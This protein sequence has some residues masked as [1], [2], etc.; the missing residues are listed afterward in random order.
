MSNCWFVRH[1]GHGVL[2][3]Q[4]GREMISSPF[5]SELSI[6]AS[7]LP[8]SSCSWRGPAWSPEE[9]QRAVRGSV[10]PP[11]S[12]PGWC[13]VVWLPCFLSPSLPPR[14]CPLLL[15]HP[16]GQRE[17]SRRAP[18]A[19]RGVPHGTG[20]GA[21][22]AQLAGTGASLCAHGLGLAC[23]C[24]SVLVFILL[25]GLRSFVHYFNAYVCFAATQSCEEKL[26]AWDSPGQTLELE[27]ARSEP[28]LTPVVPFVH[29]S[30]P[31][32]LA[33]G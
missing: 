19:L 12:S 20:C 1:N 14:T 11:R 5:C 27:R 13:A 31:C 8:R 6:T 24:I 25:S 29:S 16:P 28:L 7:L 22:R 2:S 26:L 15:C 17:L 21:E 9:Q 32:K 10:L 3:S 4:N 33:A 30:A 23:V 18:P